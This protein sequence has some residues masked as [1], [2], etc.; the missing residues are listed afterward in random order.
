MVYVCSM[1]YVDRLGG[2]LKNFERAT[3]DIV[4]KFLALFF[5]RRSDSSSN[6]Y[7]SCYIPVSVFNFVII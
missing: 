6:K 2:N 7:T 1:Q 3:S 4:D 5:I